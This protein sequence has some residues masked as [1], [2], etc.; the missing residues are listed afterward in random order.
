MMP[1]HDVLALC[2]V[3]FADAARFVARHHRHH[4]PP[5][6]HKFSIG[7]EAGGELVGVVIVGRPVAPSLR[8]RL[9]A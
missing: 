2:P 9:D 8:R 7:V 5:V 4:K 1:T 6:G 3:S